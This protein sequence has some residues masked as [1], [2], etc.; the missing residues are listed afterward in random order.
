MSSYDK[1]TLERFQENLNSGRYSTIAGA[2]RAIGK[3][4]WTDKEKNKARA[5]VDSHFTAPSPVKTTKTRTKKQA[6]L[7]E[8]DKEIMQEAS[9]ELSD[10][11]K[12]AVSADVVRATAE[13][14]RV[15]ASI[16]DNPSHSRVSTSSLDELVGLL[17]TQTKTY[18]SLAS[19]ILEA[20]KNEANGV[21]FLAGEELAVE[22]DEVHQLS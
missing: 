1:L 13:A 20:E 11:F 12:L 4:D 14:V 2:R 3:A 5:L 15:I 18:N 10:E 22:P 6:E 8:T 16:R 9:V 19:K 21:T 7:E 17:V